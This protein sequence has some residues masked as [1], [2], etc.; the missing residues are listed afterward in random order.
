MTGGHKKS[1]VRGPRTTWESRAEFREN[2]KI[3]FCS[4]VQPLGDESGLLPLDAP[5]P[6]LLPLDKG[7]DDLLLPFD[8]ALPE[9]LPIGMPLLDTEHRS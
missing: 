7:L 2:R 1:C 9:L 3:F 6:E 4:D 5:M 8:A